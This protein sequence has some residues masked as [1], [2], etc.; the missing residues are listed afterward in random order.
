MRRFLNVHQGLQRHLEGLPLKRTKNKAAPKMIA[1]KQ[2]KLNSSNLNVNEKANKKGKKKYA[3]PP[4]KVQSKLDS[5]RADVKSLLNESGKRTA[6]TLDATLPAP[7]VLR[8]GSICSGLCSEASVLGENRL[9]VPHE[10]VFS[11]EIDEKVQ[12]LQAAL[13]AN[14]KKPRPVVA[15]SGTQSSIIV[16]T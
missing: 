9:G 7:T 16:A 1:K 13:H 6:N 3:K 11:V 10:V 2:A 4:R 5:L 12:R 14:V 15:M 8:V